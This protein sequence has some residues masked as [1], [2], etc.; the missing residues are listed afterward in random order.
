[1]KKFYLIGIILLCSFS[2]FSQKAEFLYFKAKLSCCQ[3]RSCNALEG[4]I[5]KIIESN[6][7]PEEVVFKTVLIDAPENKELV[8]KYQAKSQTC[9]LIVNHK[10]NVLDYNLTTFVRN[11]Q[12]ASAEDKKF[13]EQDLILEIKKNLVMKKKKATNHD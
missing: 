6:F 1:M 3:A 11:Y 10:K 4:E 7:K 9:I 2:I 5:K 12:I 13:R 8:E